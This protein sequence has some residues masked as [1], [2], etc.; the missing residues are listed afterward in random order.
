MRRIRI[1]MACLVATLGMSAVAS[2]N[3]SAHKTRKQVEQELTEKEDKI[4]SKQTEE[5]TVKSE[6]ASEKNA[7]SSATKTF[8]EDAN[9][10][11]EAEEIRE[12][13]ETDY[14]EALA[15]GETEAAELYKTDLENEQ[16]IVGKLAAAK[17][18]AEE[19][20]DAIESRIESLE[21]RLKTLESELGPFEKEIKEKKTELVLIIINE[22]VK[23]AKPC[24][25][26]IAIRFIGTH[27]PGN[28]NGSSHI[29]VGTI[30]IIVA[31]GKKP[32]RL[33]GGVVENEAGE[34]QLVAEEGIQP[35]TAVEQEVSG[36]LA[37][38]VDGSLLS[39]KTRSTYEKDV[40]S[41]KGV[42]TATIELAAPASAVTLNES[43]L[44]ERP[45]TA[46]G[47]P[48]K[49]RLNNSFLGKQCYIGSDEDPI[50]IDLT[51]GTTSPPPPAE[52]LTGSVGEL[53][54]SKSGNLIGTSDVLVGN[55][56]AAPE[57]SGCGTAAGSIDAAIDAQTGLPS[58][59]GHNA[60][61]LETVIL[62]GREGAL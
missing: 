17:R 29:E 48:V 38:V 13:D 33:R 21:S 52:S 44:F 58:G 1:L 41:G 12:Q 31:S 18:K 59:A 35:L 27:L 3:A 25:T 5:S 19:A 6:L 14:Q 23:E 46:L 36:G 39:G 45:G 56:F 24:N 47:L 53:V 57:A 16:Q 37:S 60:A 11:S 7:L 51:T 4:K 10:L 2:A 22:N 61:L 9:A 15:N 55:S 50:V 34:Q 30:K 49:I 43:S 28:G 62:R 40:S 54:T 8:N 32:L 26:C 20:V 42:V